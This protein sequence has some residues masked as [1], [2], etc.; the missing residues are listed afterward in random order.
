MPSQRYEL[1]VAGDVWI[2][3][4]VAGD[5][6]ALFALIDESR[7]HLSQHGDM[8]ARHYPDV[9]AVADRILYTAPNELRFG[10][11]DGL[12]LV[13]FIKLTFVSSAHVEIGYWLGARHTGMGYMT[14]SV[15]TLTAWVLQ[16]PGL[17]EVIGRVLKSNEASLAVLLRAGY[18]VH[19]LSGNDQV[20]IL[21]YPP[22][23]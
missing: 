13:G 21:M 17:S 16:S 23:R 22:M 12:T 5:A 14:A 7:T 15:R 18:G 10:I 11:W 8:T 1:W 4:L 19:P 3:Q 6:P 2:R 20:H 9:A